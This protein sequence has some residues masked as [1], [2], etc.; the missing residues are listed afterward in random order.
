MT[1]VLISVAVSYPPNIV[2]II[3]AGDDFC[4]LVLPNISHNGGFSHNASMLMGNSGGGGLDNACSPF[5]MRGPEKSL[6]RLS[7]KLNPISKAK[8]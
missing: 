1:V 8:L 5:I 7:G 2:P 4:P 3:P 6:N